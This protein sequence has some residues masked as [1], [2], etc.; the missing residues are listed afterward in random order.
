[1]AD[2]NGFRPE[3]GGV[4][5]DRFGGQGAKFGIQEPDGM[6]GVDQWAAEGEQPERRKVFAGNTAADGRVRW[7]N[8][9]DAHGIYYPLWELWLIRCNYFQYRLGRE[10]L[11]RPEDE[12]GGT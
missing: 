7:I 3:G 11:L 8:E 6:P 9:Q 12:W 2:E 5:D 4:G 10:G 1:M